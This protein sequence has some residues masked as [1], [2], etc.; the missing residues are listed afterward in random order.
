MLLLWVVLEYVDWVGLGF[1]GIIG[2]CVWFCWVVL[3]G[4]L[5]WCRFWYCVGSLGWFLGIFGFCFRVCW[6]GIGV[7]GLVV[8]WDCLDV[9]WVNFLWFVI[10]CLDCVCVFVC[11]VVLGLCWSFVWVYGGGFF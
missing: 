4:V 5:V 3:V 8:G 10:V 1:F 7:L 11:R 6:L 9:F 2:C